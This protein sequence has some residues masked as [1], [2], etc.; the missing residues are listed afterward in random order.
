ML[1][2]LVCLNMRLSMWILL[3]SPCVALAKFWFA[4]LILELAF[5]LT[6]F[7]IRYALP[8]IIEVIAVTTT[9]IVDATYCLWRRHKTVPISGVD[10]FCVFV[11]AVLHF[12]V[13]ARIEQT[14]C[15]LQCC[16]ATEYVLS[17]IALT[18]TVASS[19]IGRFVRITVFVRRDD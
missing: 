9:C 16:V 2:Q 13:L 8:M 11:V 18:A 7:V 10:V 15:P 5:F 17:V 4:T 19:V 14:L 3:S 1:Q 12:F 6:Y